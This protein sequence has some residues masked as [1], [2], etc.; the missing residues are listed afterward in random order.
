MERR[1][2]KGGKGGERGTRKKVVR[3]STSQHKQERT[4]FVTLTGLEVWGNIFPQR[5]TPPLH[6]STG[7][8][9]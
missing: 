3:H 5:D 4:W 6:P 9:Q 8:L 1:K 7:T 2:E